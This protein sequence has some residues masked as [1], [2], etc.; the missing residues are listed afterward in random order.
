M[1]FELVFL[2]SEAGNTSGIL[3]QSEKIK[4]LNS[5]TLG[6]CPFDRL[7]D[8]GIC[9]PLDAWSGIHSYDRFPH[10]I[11]PLFLIKQSTTSNPAFFNNAG[12]FFIPNSNHSPNVLTI[13]FYGIIMALSIQIASKKPLKFH[14][15]SGKMD[16]PLLLYMEAIIM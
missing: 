6:F 13:P 1:P 2:T 3:L 11:I 5:C 14:F 4:L 10:N 15:R 8:Q 12:H 7:I 9:I 16:V